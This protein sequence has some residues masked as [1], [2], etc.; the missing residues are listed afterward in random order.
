MIGEA[1]AVPTHGSYLGDLGNSGYRTLLNLV[2]RDYTPAPEIAQII[3]GLLQRCY[4]EATVESVVGYHNKY[5]TICGIMLGE[6]VAV[7]RFDSCW[8]VVAIPIQ[9]Y[10]NWA[11]KHSYA[12]VPSNLPRC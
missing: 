4:P 9:A 6:Y 12:Q 7:Y 3:L 2:S 10:K 5:F 11:E 1:Y 8:K